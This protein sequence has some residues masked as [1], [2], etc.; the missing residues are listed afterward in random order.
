MRNRQTMKQAGALLLSL[1]I[2]GGTVFPAGQIRAA[3]E[4]KQPENGMKAATVSDAEKIP[5]TTVP[6][7]LSRR[8]ETMGKKRS[9]GGEVY[10]SASSSNA[11]WDS[12]AGTE[13]DPYISLAYA[14]DQ[15]EDGDTIC[16][17]S[18]LTE[19]K[20]AR[21]WD[22]DLTIDGQGHTVFRGDG[23][24]KAQDL[25]RGGYHP[26]MI[27]VGGTRPGEAQT[28]SLTLTD[29]V[30][31]DGGKT[32]GVNFKQASTDG[33]GGNESLVQDAIVA[34]YNGTAEII[35]ASGATLRNFGGMSAV[36]LSGG[37]LVMEDGS[38]ICDDTDGVADRTKEKGDYGAAGAVWIQG[39]SFRMEAGAEISHMRGRAVYLDGGSA[40]IGGSISDIRSDKD[41]WQGGAGAAVHVRNEGTAVLSQ[42]GSIKGIAGESA[43]HTV[44]DTASGDFEAVSGSEI[45][46][47]RDIMVASAND[48]ENDYVHKMLLNGLISDCTTKDSLMRSWYAEI[49]VGPTGQVTGCT[50]TGEGGLLYTHNGSRYVFEG[51]I[52]GNTALKGIV[53]L[54][55]QGG[56]RVSARMLEGAEISNNKGLG[57]K[58]NN[59]ALLTM[60]GG[61]NLGQYGS[62]D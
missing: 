60:E 35:L 38:Q 19:T 50:A 42:S 3:A 29:I 36:R 47:C 61:R 40:E 17:M 7:L 43:E 51:K 52:T 9:S 10:V 24:E 39:G 45:S 41:M 4:T 5:G 27:E 56:G 49:T 15:A 11:R 13:E 28:A 58:V 6:G 44:I 18:D 37:D 8:P 21:F 31:D 54:A 23:F 32:E 25:A 59:G 20:S 62:R 16:L 46:G 48:Y 33:K 14:V 30:L 26:A 12:G 22:K 53:Y 55:N 2:I 1:A 34:T 57:I